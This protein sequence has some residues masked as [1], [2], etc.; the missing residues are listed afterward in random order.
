[1]YIWNDFFKK[2]NIFTL[3]K[4]KPF[5]VPAPFSAEFEYLVLS[6]LHRIWVLAQWKSL[7]KARSR[8][9]KLPFTQQQ[10]TGPGLGREPEPTAHSSPGESAPTGQPLTGPHSTTCQHCV[11]LVCPC[12]H[13]VTMPPTADSWSSSLTFM[14]EWLWWSMGRQGSW[15]QSVLLIL[16]ADVQS[17]TQQ[18]CWYPWEGGTSV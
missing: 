10:P 7:W 17:H 3:K 13:Y 4:K 9:E 1:M 2:L 12:W 11:C 16:G 18:E 15:G 14:P 6:W 5:L 8:E